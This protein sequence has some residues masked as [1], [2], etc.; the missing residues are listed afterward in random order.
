MPGKRSDAAIM[1]FDRGLVGPSKGEWYW[2]PPSYAVP[3]PVCKLEGSVCPAGWTVRSQNG[4]GG[5]A[6][7][8]MIETHATFLTA[9]SLCLR[10]DSRASLASALVAAD[11]TFVKDL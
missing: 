11:N 10:E 5:K 8:K 1:N 9:I 2:T 6:C 4:K 3:F 7:Y